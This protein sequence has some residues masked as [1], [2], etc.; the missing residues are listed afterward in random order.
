[1][2][3]R[4]NFC[5]RALL[6]LLLAAPAAAQEPAPPEPLFVT[7]GNSP[8]A[9]VGML[10]AGIGDVNG[11]GY[12]DALVG[13]PNTLTVF[14]GVDGA[15]LYL[16]YPVTPGDFENATVLAVP[17]L[18]GDGVGD[19]LVGAPRVVLSG[20]K[21][22]GVLYL[23]SGAGGWGLRALAGPGPQFRQE[24]GASLALLDD[25]DGDGVPEVAIGAPGSRTVT[26]PEA[27]SV[28][29]LSLGRGRILHV[30]RGAEASWRLGA[31]LATVGDLDGDGQRDLAVGVPGESRDGTPEV[32]AV[33]LYSSANGQ[34]LA[35]LFGEREGG[36]FGAALAAAG[37]LD[38]DGW[39]DLLV[40]T[41][42]RAAGKEDAPGEVW[43]LSPADGR[44]ILHLP[45]PEGSRDFGAVV[46]AGGD[47]DGDGRPDLLIGA[48]GATVDGRQGAGLVRAF[49]GTG[50]RLLL[51]LSGSAG[52][53]MGASLAFAGDLNGDGRADALVG[54]P[55]LDLLAVP[56]VGAAMAFALTR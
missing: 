7:S 27:G 55:Y 36:R 1:M 11:D 40:G 18:D 15:L 39:V 41:P 35:K 51:T 16:V 43:V 20:Q 26:K 38:G 12:D 17:D 34:R 3:A 13:T 23:F 37:D 33:H 48:P 19:F 52:D 4:K 30:I 25:L 50:G 46:A 32:G 21:D 54:A 47:F 42:G 10:V 22:A 28:T 31:S 56:D 9:H 5:A 44:K 14:S 53:A 2:P 49:S 6:G 29:I 8:G 45:G 24:F